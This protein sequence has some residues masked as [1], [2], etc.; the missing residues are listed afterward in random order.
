MTTKSFL[1]VGRGIYA[2][3]LLRIL[4]SEPT[5]S[6]KVIFATSV[7]WKDFGSVSRYVDE[8][9]DEILRDLDLS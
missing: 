4:K 1:V 5:S 6:T 8:V 7:G 2:L 3:P 9:V